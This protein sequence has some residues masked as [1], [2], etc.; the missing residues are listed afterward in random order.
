MDMAF[1]YS[2]A[3]LAPI[4]IVAWLWASRQGAGPASSHS[5]TLYIRAPK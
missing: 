3:G 1:T 5:F 4:F 2:D